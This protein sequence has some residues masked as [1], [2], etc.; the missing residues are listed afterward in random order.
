MSVWAGPPIVCLWA[1]CLPVESNATISPPQ[2]GME[3][4]R[5]SA[6]TRSADP[7]CARA[8]GRGTRSSSTMPSVG[9]DFAFDAACPNAAAGTKSASAACSAFLR[10]HAI[11]ATTHRGDDHDRVAIVDRRR[12]PVDESNAVFADE[13]VGVLAHLS[14]F[15]HHAVEYSRP[16]FADRREGVLHR[17]ARVVDDERAAAA[18]VGIERWRQDDGDGHGW[19]LGFSASRRLGSIYAALGAEVPAPT[20]AARTQTT[21]GSALAMFCQLSPAFADPETLP[22]RVPK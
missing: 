7:R 2:R 11:S 19:L 20:T 1:S 15:R 14:L 17:R 22:L 9:G 4:M 6:P 21:G 18:R 16:V 10:M 3:I 13:H 5:P 8:S 12:Q